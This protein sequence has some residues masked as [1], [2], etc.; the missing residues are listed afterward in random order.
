MKPDE[1]LAHTRKLLR[2]HA[3]DDPDK[4]WYAN[5]FVFARLQLDERK[6]KTSIKRQFMDEMKPCHYCKKPFET[7]RD[8]HLHRLDGDKGYSESN[9]ALM[10]AECHQKYHSES[11]VENE[12]QK[13]EVSV[14]VKRSK[15]Y[16]DINKAFT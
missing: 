13:S 1:I 3:N 10:H 9:C 2:E 8:I 5:R 16:K 11:S 6:T 7:K 14:L 4:W 12:F 15:R